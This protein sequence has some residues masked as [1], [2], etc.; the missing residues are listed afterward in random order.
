MRR[1]QRSRGQALVEFALA[2]PI[3]LMLMMAVFDLGRAIYMYNGVAQ[4]ARELAR[5]TSVY[6]GTPGALGS[7]TQTAAV[8]ATQKALIPSLGNPTFTCVDIDGSSCHRNVRGRDAGQGR[9]RRPVC[10]GD[11]G[12]EP[13]RHPELGILEHVL[14]PAMSTAGAPSMSANRPDFEPRTRTR[15]DHRHLRAGPGRDHR[16]GRPG[17]RR[18]LSVRHAPRRA[19]RGRPGR[20]GSGQRLHAQ[21]RHGGGDR[22]RPHRRRSERLYARRERRRRQRHDHDEQRG[23]GAGRHQRAA[24]QQLRLDRRDAELACRHDRQGTGR[25]SGHGQRRRAD[26]LQ[27]RRIRTERPAAGGLRRPEQPVRLRRDQ[28]RYPDVPR[29]TSPG[30]TTAPATSTPTRSTT[31]SSATAPST[32]RSPSASTSASTTTATTRRCSAT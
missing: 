17:P 22:P 13:G 5:V 28:R 29:A 16:D 11:P 19:E 12:P 25:L 15:P 20:P 31:S 30:P 8:L 4:A 32:R 7:T 2:L 26:H 21:F 3:F 6:P 9:D 14:D 27:H 18:W 24:P 23:R 1:R 10:A